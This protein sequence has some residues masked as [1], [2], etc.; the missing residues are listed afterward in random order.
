LGARWSR[1]TAPTLPPDIKVRPHDG[2]EKFR[3]LIHTIIP[4]VYLTIDIASSRHLNTCICIHIYTHIYVYVYI[5]MCVC[6]CVPSECGG[7]EIAPEV[8]IVST[9][10]YDSA[11]CN[12]IPHLCHLMQKL[13]LRPTATHCNPLQPTATHCN[14]L[15]LIPA[16]CNTLQHTTTHCNVPHL[17][18]WM[19]KL[20]FK[21]KRA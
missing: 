2:G 7:V 17:R 19:Q 18:L 4:G 13:A 12:N 8:E 1:G 10:S 20:V 15:Q 9:C 14:P 6:A 11:T 3:E 5:Y 16:H 21:I